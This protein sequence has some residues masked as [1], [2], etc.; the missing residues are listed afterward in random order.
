MTDREKFICNIM[1]E[2]YIKKFGK[3]KWNKLSGK[4][5]F[6][7]KLGIIYQTLEIMEKFDKKEIKS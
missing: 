6:N 2:Q 4:E 5:Q 7:I 3:R 1:I